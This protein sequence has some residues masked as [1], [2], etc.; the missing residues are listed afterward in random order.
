V[1]TLRDL[2]VDPNATVVSNAVAALSEIGDRNDG[3]TFKLNFHVVN[4]LLAALGESS[5]YV[6]RVVSLD[7][8]KPTI[9]LQMGSNLHLGLTVEVC[10]GRYEGRRN[11]CGTDH[12]SNATCKLCRGSHH[13][14][15]SA[16][17]D[18]LHG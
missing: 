5:E 8:S 3:V 1:E 10:S 12:R 18:E 2:L 13:N 16:V 7:S 6:L 9:S 4:K 17:F 14:Q 11:T 15:N